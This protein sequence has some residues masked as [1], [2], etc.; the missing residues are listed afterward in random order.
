MSKLTKNSNQG[1]PAFNKIYPAF[2]YCF[3]TIYLTSNLSC[4]S[5]TTIFHLVLPFVQEFF[6]LLFEESLK[7]E[8]DLFT[9]SSATSAL[10]F[11][12][13]VSCSSI[14][15]QDKMHSNRIYLHGT[16]RVWKEGK[17]S[18]FHF[19]P[20]RVLALRAEHEACNSQSNISILLWRWT[21]RNIHMSYNWDVR[22]ERGLSSSAAFQINAIEDWQ[23]KKK[24]R[25][26]WTLD[27]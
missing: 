25:Q 10:W 9:T 20:G 18:N 3:L 19:F 21:V 16:G 11:K 4:H 14:G 15:W 27:K 23:H 1:G 17:K 2:F 7:T 6:L 8:S 13:S 26:R 5:L 22:R 24:K 12:E